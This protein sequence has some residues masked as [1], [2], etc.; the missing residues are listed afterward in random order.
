MLNIK[1]IYCLLLFMS[2]I[3]RQ[4][5]KKNFPLFQQ[6]VEPKVCNFNNKAT[7]RYM[8]ATLLK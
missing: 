4:I 2:S 6:K 1:Y 7:S 8:S 3:Y 5:N